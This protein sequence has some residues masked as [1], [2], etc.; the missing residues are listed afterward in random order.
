MKWL[1][2]ED[3]EEYRKRSKDLRRM[4][5]VAGQDD[6]LHCMLRIATNK[7]GHDQG[8]LRRSPFAGSIC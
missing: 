6:F 1:E 8:L 3:N 2:I 7:L 5:V 4:V